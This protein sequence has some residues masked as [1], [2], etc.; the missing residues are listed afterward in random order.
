[1]ITGEQR[2]TVSR[3]ENKKF[4]GFTPVTVAAINPTRRELN[5]LLGR[6]DSDNDKEIIY[7]AEDAD[8]NDKVRLTFYLHAEA[9]DKY[10]PYSFTLINK[11]RVS[12]DGLKKQYVNNTCGTSWADSPD[13]LDKWFTT[14]EDREGNELGKKTVREALVGE[15]ELMT[16][17]K[18]WLGRLNFYNAAANVVVDTNKLF[19]E[20]YSELRNIIGGHYDTPFVALFGVRTDEGDSEKQYQTIYGKSFLP[21]SMM[22]GIKKGMKFSKE[23]QRKSWTKFETEVEGQYGFTDSYFELKELKEYDKTL[24]VTQAESGITPTNSKY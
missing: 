23:P 11:V 13:N 4:V 12:K 10:V 21:M 14:F 22:D 8:G 9:I 15:E 7:K 20:D 6:E 5:R 17:L 1:M 18:S 2:E 3:V 19:K 24:D 16:I